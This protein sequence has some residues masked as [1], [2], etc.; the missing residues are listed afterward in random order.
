MGSLPFAFGGRPRCQLKNADQRGPWHLP[1]ADATFSCDTAGLGL[2][3]GESDKVNDGE[4]LLIQF[5]QDVLIESAALVAGNDGVC[6]GFY[7]RRRRRTAGDLLCGCRQRRP[8][9]EWRAQ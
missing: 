2:T 3:G 7:T 1:L 6:G 8:R 9:S 4:A 5:D